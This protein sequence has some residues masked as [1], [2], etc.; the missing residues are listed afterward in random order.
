MCTVGLTGL[1]AVLDSAAGQWERMKLKCSKLQQQHLVNFF[2]C[3]SSVFNTRDFKTVI[4]SV[5]FLFCAHCDYS[6]A[7]L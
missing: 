1:W 2:I 3:I 4:M 5:C 6:L 7:Y